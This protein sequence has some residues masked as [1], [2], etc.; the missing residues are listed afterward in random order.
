MQRETSM[1]PNEARQALRE[2]DQIDTELQPLTQQ[3]KPLN[4]R[5]RQLAT[6]LL[7]HVQTL[8]G[9]STELGTAGKRWRLSAVR[10]PGSVRYK[11]E[12]LKHISPADLAQI[13]A[14]QPPTYKLDIE[15]L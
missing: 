8:P 2:L 10:K 1:T 11:E 7:E 3:I 12:L 13:A 5:R 15:P 9:K 6:A 4:D 14:G